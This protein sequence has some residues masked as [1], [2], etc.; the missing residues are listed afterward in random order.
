MIPKKKPHYPIHSF[1]FLYVPLAPSIC[2]KNFLLLAELIF[3]LKLHVLKRAIPESLLSPWD[4]GHDGFKASG[5]LCVGSNIFSVCHY[6][7]AQGFFE[8]VCVRRKWKPWEQPG[9]WS[10]RLTSLIS[11]FFPFHL[12]IFLF[13]VST[14]MLTL[15]MT[16][17]HAEEMLLTI[18][19]WTFIIWAVSRQ[20]CCSFC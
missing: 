13:H 9:D 7:W 4:W 3:F 16:L 20:L 15:V 10:K 19:L 14:D 8:C 18:W 5:I 2:Y 6:E 11:F 17:L 1:P 12:F